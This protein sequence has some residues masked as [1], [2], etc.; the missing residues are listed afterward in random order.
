MCTR[1]RRERA[2]TDA[3]ACT[4]GGG[5]RAAARAFGGP[6]VSGTPN[7][8]VSYTARADIA[9]KPATGKGFKNGIPLETG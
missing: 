5:V 4:F 2:G 1:Q 7:R 3:A 6:P 8:S 9:L